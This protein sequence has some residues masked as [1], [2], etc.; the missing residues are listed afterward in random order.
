MNILYPK[1]RLRLVPTMLGY[2]A[3]GGVLAGLYGVLHD[4]ITYSISPEYF[5]N[6]KFDQFHWAD[7]GLPQRIFVGEIGFLATWWV[8]FFAAWFLARITVPAL[9]PEVAFR[10]ALRGFAIVFAF[11]FAGGVVG[12]VLGLIRL[13]NSDYSSWDDFRLC[14]DL[15]DVPSFV[16]VAY[17]HNAGYLGGLIGAIIAILYVRRVKNRYQARLNQSGIREASR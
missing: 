14:Y 13:T 4:Q 17:I 8:G 3:L 12:Y 15:T 6:L 2:A 10:Y 5:T 11:G 9:P 16:R 1:I 7:L